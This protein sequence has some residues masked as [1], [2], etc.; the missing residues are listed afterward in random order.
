MVFQ[1]IEYSYLQIENS[2][3]GVSAVQ[4][5][6]K[7]S[8]DIVR[9]LFFENYF[10]DAMDE[11]KAQLINRLKNGVSR[12][13]L[14]RLRDSINQIRNIGAVVGK[15]YPA[16]AFLLG[17]RDMD[18]YYLASAFSELV[19]SAEIVDVIRS[20]KQVGRLPLL[21][22]P[23]QPLFSD[24]EI[25]LRDFR[26][27]FS[28]WS[29]IREIRIAT[30]HTVQSSSGTSICAR[31]DL[32]WIIDFFT[33]IDDMAFIPTRDFDSMQVIP[34]QE[35]SRETLPRAIPGHAPWKES[36]AKDADLIV[37][38]FWDG[39]PIDLWSLI[40]IKDIGFYFEGIILSVLDWIDTKPKV[41]S[42]TPEMTPEQAEVLEIIRKHGAITAPDI[43]EKLTF[44]VTAKTLRNECYL[45]FLIE[46]YNVENQR[47]KDKSGR[48][49]YFVRRDES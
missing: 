47:R 41:D 19:A 38:R 49:G 27:T 2:I 34:K 5:K 42:K 48:R 25:W 3:A 28:T 20:S 15:A 17:D 11:K 9:Y 10:G 43:C 23:E 46:H 21:P 13:R 22:K 8:R 26:S 40:L 30:N 44:Q 32:C 39:Q 18:D 24:A 45:P 35:I 31:S 33:F 4:S 12:N 36:P 7:I 1:Y 37:D 6:E 16:K 29:V 14:L